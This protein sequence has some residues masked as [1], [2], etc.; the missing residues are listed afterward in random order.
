MKKDNIKN[1]WINACSSSSRNIAID[2]YKSIELEYISKKRHYHNLK[3]IGSLFQLIENQNIDFESKKAL[4]NVALFHDIVYNPTRLD[5]E[6][7][8]AQLAKKW[9]KKLGVEKNLIEQVF[10]III[11]TKN[12]SSEDYMTQLFL[13][14]DLS[15]LGADKKDYVI[16]TKQIRK[17]F[18]LIPTVIYR[19]GRINFLRN[20]L[21]SNSIFKTNKFIEQFEQ[22][23]RVNIQNELAIL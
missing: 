12:H 16:Y 5:N 9:L 1:I 15:I 20:L 13:D 6:L 19:K 18:L 17:E 14:M 21:K 3:H 22:Q 10:S 2:C 7:K 8:S 4:Y 23:A 11:A